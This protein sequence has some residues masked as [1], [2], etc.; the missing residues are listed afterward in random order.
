[1]CSPHKFIL[2]ISYVGVHQT[3]HEGPLQGKLT[4]TFLLC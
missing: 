2:V 3:V 1:M 4:T